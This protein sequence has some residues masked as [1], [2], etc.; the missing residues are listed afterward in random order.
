MNARLEQSPTLPPAP[1]PAVIY[2]EK[3][4][5][6]VQ[7]RRYGAHSQTESAIYCTLS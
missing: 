3:G 1:V 7:L 6:C 2:H 5:L 4:M